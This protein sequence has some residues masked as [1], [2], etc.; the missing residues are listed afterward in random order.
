MRYL[1]TFMA[2]RPELEWHHSSIDTEQAA[3]KSGWRGVSPVVELVSLCDPAAELI[4]HPQVPA[5][6][7]PQYSLAL[8]G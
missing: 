7:R 5:V 1:E 6:S 8:T 2:Q 3:Y 4:P